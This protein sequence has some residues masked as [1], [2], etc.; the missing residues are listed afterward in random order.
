MCHP[1]GGSAPGDTIA[2]ARRE[3]AAVI[4]EM[5]LEHR[6]HDAIGAAARSSRAGRP[7]APRHG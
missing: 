7:A 4:A 3:E 1:G 5:P 2:T 6:Y